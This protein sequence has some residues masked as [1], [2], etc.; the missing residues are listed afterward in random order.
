MVPSTH[1]G[2]AARDSPD[3]F[4]TLLKIGSER[5]DN[6]FAEQNGS[7]FSAIVVTC[8]KTHLGWGMGG[9]RGEGGRTKGVWE[10]GCLLSLHGN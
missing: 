4:S 3:S 5:A 9:K 7:A 1:P 6:L 2:L 8:F 10:I